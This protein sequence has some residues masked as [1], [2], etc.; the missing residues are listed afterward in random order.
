M[1]IF[2]PFGSAKLPAELPLH[3]I[4][5]SWNLFRPLQPLLLLLLLLPLLLLLLLVFPVEHEAEQRSNVFNI[6][7]LASRLQ[8]A[9]EWMEVTGKLPRDFPVGF[10]GAS[11]GG[12]KGAPATSV[13]R[14]LFGQLS[15]V[16]E[17]C[18]GCIMENLISSC[19]WLAL[20]RLFWSQ[21]RWAAVGCMQHV[22]P[23]VQGAQCCR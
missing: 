3:C 17:C 20:R 14:H 4:H 2:K 22:A 21:H 12:L 9:V 23:H 5:T 16:V 7:L 6:A 11:T 10:F 8:L 19:C 18:T 15:A 1:L 13:L